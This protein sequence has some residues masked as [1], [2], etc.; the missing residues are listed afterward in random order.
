MSDA[1][2][3]LSQ[4]AEF[5]KWNLSVACADQDSFVRGGPTLTGFFCCFF[6]VCV[7]FFVDER[8]ED[9]ST[10]YHYK[11]AIIGPPAK[12]HLMAFGWRADDDPTLNA[13]LVAAIFQGIWTCIARKPYIFVI[14]QGCPDP[15]SP[16][17]D[18]RELMLWTNHKYT[19][20]NLLK[21]KQTN[22][23]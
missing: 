15:L 17:L 19:C 18:P 6:F 4:S 5:L 22:S 21:R 11:R 16:P 12:H 20:I 9:P 3:S 23:P 2:I 10:L 1:V 8:W 14:F 7:F 13:G